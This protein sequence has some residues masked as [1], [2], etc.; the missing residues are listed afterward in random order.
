MAWNPGIP[1]A[2]QFI[3]ASQPLL[4][5]NFQALDTW[6][7]VDH[8]GIDSGATNGMHEWVRYLS[9][10]NSPDTTIANMVA[11]VCGQGPVSGNRELFFI[12][13]N[14]APAALNT[15]KPWTEYRTNT[16]G[17]N[18][19]YFYVAG[20]RLLI[21]FNRIDAGANPRT[22]NYVGGPA[23]QVGSV[24]T[25]ITQP[26]SA[27]GPAFFVCNT[28]N[29]TDASFTYFTSNSTNNYSATAIR[30]VSIGIPA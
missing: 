3:S 22:Y 18:D 7:K 1:T 2:N 9:Q 25:V 24:P 6:S 11:L 8:T 17:G 21:K 27:G 5:G 28:T 10:L 20:G 23:F 29:S 14:T 26:L 4:L 16:V 15:L 12:P 13:N 19:G 30:F